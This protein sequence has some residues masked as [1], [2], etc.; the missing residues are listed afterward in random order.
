MVNL[1]LFRSV[2]GA[3]LPKTD[4]TNEAPRKR[5][6][7]W[8]CSDRSRS[9]RSSLAMTGRP[10]KALPSLF[11]CQTLRTSSRGPAESTRSVGSG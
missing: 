1:N 8:S 9:R 10:R 2:F 6:R 11:P 5:T 4:T 3:L 7:L